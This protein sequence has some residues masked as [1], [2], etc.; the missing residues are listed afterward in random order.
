MLHDMINALLHIG[1]MRRQTLDQTLGNLS[2]KHAAFTAG[3][4]KSGIRVTEKL[5][6]QKIKHSV[7]HRRRREDLIV[8]QIGKAVQ[9]I[10]VIYG[11]KKII[12]HLLQASCNP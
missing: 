4:E 5:L 7:C 9:H 12:L 10:G 8:G 3:V 11:S 1:I 2:E 6:R